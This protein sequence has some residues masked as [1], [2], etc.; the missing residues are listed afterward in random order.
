MSRILSACPVWLAALLVLLMAVAWSGGGVS[1]QV[2]TG[3]CHWPADVSGHA[4][5]SGPTGHAA[6]EL[7]SAGAGDAAIC[8]PHGCCPALVTIEAGSEV[9]A[10][11][12]FY[13][14]P[15]DRHGLPGPS[16]SFERPPQ[17]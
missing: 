13:P 5:M 2:H 16:W 17:A 8:V 12:Q 6:P 14:R 9:G 4:G 15:E 10:V 1:Q 11:R 7:S 3:N